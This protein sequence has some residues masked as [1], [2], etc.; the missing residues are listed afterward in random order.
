MAERGRAKEYLNGDITCKMNWSCSST[1]EAGDRH[2][3]QREQP[4]RHLGENVQACSGSS[5][6]HRGCGGLGWMWKQ[7]E[8]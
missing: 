3:G 6:W 7:I 1:A 2:S 4:C 5:N 8:G